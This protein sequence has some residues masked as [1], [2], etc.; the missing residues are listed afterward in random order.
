MSVV[1]S[2]Q[3]LR[4][5]LHASDRLPVVFLGHG[6]PMNAI[7]DTA[8]SRS[9]SDLGRT[10]PRPQAILVVSAH[11]MTKGTTLVDVS[12][13]PRIIHDF[14]GFPQELYAQQYPAPGNPELARDVVALLSSHHAQEDDSWGLDHGAWTVLK[15]LYPGADVP[16]FQLSIDMSQ[17]LDWHLQIGRTL[18]ELRDR[19]VLILGSGNIV[20]NL[21]ALSQTGTTP[22]FALEFDSLFAERL[23]ERNLGALADRKG[24]GSLLHQAHPSVDHYLPALTIAGA[25]DERDELT[26][27][28]DSFDLGSV[29]MRSFVFHS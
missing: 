17:D 24:L 4:D 20:H 8:Y 15:F 7:E 11:W 22:D 6:N 29:S 2:L 9:W 14:Y 19:G 13:M 25:S 28:N 18:S 12:A 21:R 27:M 23:T 26:F 1:Q 10:L 5:R 3:S 16:V